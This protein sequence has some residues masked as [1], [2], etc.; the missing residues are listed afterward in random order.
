M[1]YVSQE[2]IKHA[3]S[4]SLPFTVLHLRKRIKVKSKR[5]QNPYTVYNRLKFNQMFALVSKK[6]WVLLKIWAG[7][8][9]ASKIPSAPYLEPGDQKQ[10]V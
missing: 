5:H 9:L 8:S 2:R 10:I 6:C 3:I 7:W 4:P 1:K